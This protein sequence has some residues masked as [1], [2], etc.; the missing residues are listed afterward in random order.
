MGSSGGVMLLLAAVVRYEKFK[1]ERICCRS[2]EG[3]GAGGTSV[4][5]SP[6]QRCRLPEAR[7]TGATENRVKCG[8]R[9]W[10]RA[11]TR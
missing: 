11:G 8:S 1:L 5:P 9:W 4:T 10:R 3:G 7:R 6:T 2:R